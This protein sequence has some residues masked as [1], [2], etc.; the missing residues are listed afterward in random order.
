LKVKRHEITLQGSISSKSNAELEEMEFQRNI[1]TLE[2]EDMLDNLKGDG[3]A[4]I[5][6]EVE[7][8]D[9]T[10]GQGVSL[11]VRISLTCD[12]SLEC[13]ETAYQYAN[14]IAQDQLNSNIPSVR[15]IYDEHISGKNGG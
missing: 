3:A 6:V 13:I 8:A 4:N 2:Y 15:R 12:Q 7:F 10:Y 9:K 5:S 1:D 14:Q 11:K